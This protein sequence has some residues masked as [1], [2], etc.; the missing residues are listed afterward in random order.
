MTRHCHHCGWEWTQPGQPGRTDRCRKCGAD[1]RICLNCAN[2]EPH[3]AYQCRDHRAELIEDKDNGNFCEYFE[4]A[5]R[6]YAPALAHNKQADWA[7]AQLKKL[8][9]D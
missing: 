4:L 7:R 5:R 1:L 3:A 6:S 8:L 9:E 2:Y